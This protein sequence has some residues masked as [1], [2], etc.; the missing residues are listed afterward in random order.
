MSIFLSL[1]YKHPEDKEAKQIE[2]DYRAVMKDFL[3]FSSYR[4]AKTLFIK[5]AMKAMNDLKEPAKAKARDKAKNNE[6]KKG[7]SGNKIKKS[8]KAKKRK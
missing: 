6:K 1:T 5:T 7:K 2:K 4:E 8:V 3:K